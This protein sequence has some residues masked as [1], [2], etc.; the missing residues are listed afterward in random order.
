MRTLPKINKMKKI[1][2]LLLA[3]YI[4][5]CSED[6]H[7]KADLKE[8]KIIDISNSNLSL[9]KT[10][11]NSDSKNIFI[12]ID[13]NLDVETFP[14]SIFTDVVISKGAKTSLNETGELTFETN[15][16]IISF[17]IE[18]EN[19]NTSSWNV[20]LVHKQLQN[21]D[22]EDWYEN[23]GLNGYFYKEIGSSSEALVW[24]TANMGTS[25]YGTYGTQPLIVENN[26]IVQVRTDSVQSIP[27][28]AATLFTGSFNLSGAIA[29]PTNPKKATNFGTPFAHSPKAFKIKYKYSAGKWYKQAT[30][31]NSSNIFGGFEEEG[32]P[33]EDQCAIYAILEKREGDSVTEIAKAELYSNSTED[34]LIESIVSFNYTSQF[35]PTHITVVFSSSKDGDLWKGAVGSTLVIDDLEF[36]YD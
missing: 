18:A 30:L 19:G 25:T 34:E 20:S 35:S 28:T 33:G 23:K 14:I 13:N 1:L 26:T 8:F 7:E 24:A 16:D 12:Y 36:I 4:I 21:S 5:S 10:E 17:D 22:F 31:K 2:Y 15:E 29:N 27:L 11:I 32:I 9:L 6:K 3:I